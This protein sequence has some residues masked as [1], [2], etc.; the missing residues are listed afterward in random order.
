MSLKYHLQI[1]CLKYFKI[2]AIL[3]FSYVRNNLKFIPSKFQHVYSIITTLFLTL[4][5]L[6]CGFCWFFYYSK[7]LKQDFINLLCISFLWSILAI[8]TLAILYQK[9]YCTDELLKL[10]NRTIIIGKEHIQQNWDNIFYR[11]F[12]LSVFKVIIIPII[13]ITIIFNTFSKFPIMLKINHAYLLHNYSYGTL[14]LLPLMLKLQVFEKSLKNLNQR[15][16]IIIDNI[17]SNKIELDR[18]NEIYSISIKYFEILKLLNETCLYYRWNIVTVLSANSF[19]FIRKLYPVMY[20]VVY[21]YNTTKWDADRMNLLILELILSICIFM[22]IISFIVQVISKV[23]Y[24]NSK[25]KIILRNLH[26]NVS[27]MMLMKT[28]SKI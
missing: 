16:K 3:P 25:T 13:W 6:Y 22:N 18:I 11:F 23:E 27:D 2:N 4:S 15:V 21:I 17:N 26:I 9:I 14:T 24:H 7:Y 1:F 20:Y 10:C 19:T 28:V 8:L 5:S 12:I